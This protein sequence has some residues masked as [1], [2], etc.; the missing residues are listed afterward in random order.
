VESASAAADN[1]QP[2]CTVS[3]GRSSSSE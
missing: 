1:L 2:S 3:S